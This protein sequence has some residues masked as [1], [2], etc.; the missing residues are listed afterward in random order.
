MVKS[1]RLR[2]KNHL[3]LS[4]KTEHQWASKRSLKLDTIG[5]SAMCGGSLFHGPVERTAKPASP[6]ASRKRGW[7]TFELYPAAGGLNKYPSDLFLI[8][9]TISSNRGTA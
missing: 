4:G 5:A 8:Q 3:Q 2:A 7:R 9:Q 1:V 6:S